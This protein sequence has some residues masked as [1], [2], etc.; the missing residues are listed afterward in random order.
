MPVSLA[1]TNWVL[2]QLLEIF[3]KLATETEESVA[4]QQRRLCPGLVKRVK[5]EKHNFASFK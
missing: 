1:L 3:S 2:G 5:D 4:W